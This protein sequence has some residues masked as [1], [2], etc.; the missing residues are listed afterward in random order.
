MSMVMGRDDSLEFLTVLLI[1]V[2]LAMDAFAV[3]ICK[4]LAM[5]RPD[6]RSMAIIGLWFGIFQAG[7]PVIGYFLGSSMYDLIS[8]YDH[9]ITFGLL[10]LIGLNMIRESLSDEEEEL[11]ADIGPWTMFILA[12]ATSID[13]FAVGISLA[14]DGTD[15]V[16]SAAIIGVITLVISVIGVKIGAKVGDRFG[17]RAEL[18]GGLILIAIGMKIVVEHLGLL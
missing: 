14:M 3:S 10:A 2:G 13:A 6:L 5:K 9:W 16:S 1:A 4:G 15:I 17:K 18:A 12:V 7:M 8:D 11:D